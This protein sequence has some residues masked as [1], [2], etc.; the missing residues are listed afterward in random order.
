[1]GWIGVRIVF[2]KPEFW[3]LVAVNGLVA[4]VIYGAN[5][6]RLR[7]IL[8]LLLIAMTVYGAMTVRTTPNLEMPM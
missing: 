5:S 8:H 2:W 6:S 4:L 7:T 3:H 1:V